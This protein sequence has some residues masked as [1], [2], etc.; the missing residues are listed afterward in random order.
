MKLHYL[1][2]TLVLAGL[3]ASAPD[4]VAGAD[5]KESQAQLEQVRQ[6]IQQLQ[7][8]MRQE[9]ARQDEVSTQLRKLDAAVAAAAGRL[10]DVEQQLADADRR[11]AA[12]GR[13]V[14]AQQA[15]IGAHREQLG[16]QL[17]AAYANSGSGYLKLLL[18]AD[19]PLR[20]G[21]ILTYH[22]YLQ[23]ARKQ[24]MDAAA[25]QLLRLSKLEQELASEK[26]VLEQLRLQALVSQQEIAAARAQRAEA[27]VA[28]EARIATRGDE[29]DRLK[30]DAA[31]LEQLLERLRGA[32]AD[33]QDLRLD[34]QPFRNGRGQLEWPLNGPLLARFGEDRG[35]GGMRWS[36]VLIQ[37]REGEP[38]RSVAR[39]HVVFADWLRGFGLLLIIDHGDGFMTLYGNNEAIFKENGDWVQPGEVIASV[40]AGGMPRAAGVYFEVRAGGKPVNP[41]QWLRPAA[42]GS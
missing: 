33:V 37:G 3:L 32:L 14:A 41:L 28:I 23:A 30:A 4:L 15:R 26:A 27:L 2:Y 38:V 40:G 19:D 18:N 42:G 39:G 29:L 21:R 35:I 1:A 22:R 9:R 17:R 13:E 8:Q 25:A 12:L 7:L 34:K 20:L 36:G 6:R 5:Y 24:E 16:Q 11:V 10:R 31:E